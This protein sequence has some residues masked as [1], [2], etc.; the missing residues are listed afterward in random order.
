MKR[1]LQWGVRQALTLGKNCLHGGYFGAKVELSWKSA[2]EKKNKNKIFEN[3]YN[4]LMDQR[5]NTKPLTVWITTNCGK[6]FKRWECQ[7]TLLV[8]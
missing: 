8:S 3:N 4:Y 6:F 7:T 2:T 5:K 1:T